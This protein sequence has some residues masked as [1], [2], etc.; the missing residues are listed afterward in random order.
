M[1]STEMNDLVRDLQIAI[2]DILIPHPNAMIG[3]RTS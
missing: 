3:I 1:S 2:D